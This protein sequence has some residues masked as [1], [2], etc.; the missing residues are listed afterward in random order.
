MRFSDILFGVMIFAGGIVTGI[1]LRESNVVTGEQI[2][3][4][5]KNTIDKVRGSWEAASHDAKTSET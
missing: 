2:K 1:F 3:K 4:T 5:T